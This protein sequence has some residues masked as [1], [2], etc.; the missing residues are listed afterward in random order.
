MVSCGGFR[1]LV[2]E[3]KTENTISVRVTLQFA[4]LN[5]Q[6]SHRELYYLSNSD[7]VYH[8]LHETNTLYRGR[9]PVCANVCARLQNTPRI[10]EE[11]LA[12]SKEVLDLANRIAGLY[13]NVYTSGKSTKRPRSE[14]G[15]LEEVP[16]EVSF[17]YKGKFL[18]L[19]KV[20]T[21]AV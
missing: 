13:S 1:G 15:D 11:L 6:V 20:F 19:K 5:F 12:K 14:S 9:K 16:E 17:E 7:Y 10:S 8:F 3:T 2:S 21:V 18:N 4:V